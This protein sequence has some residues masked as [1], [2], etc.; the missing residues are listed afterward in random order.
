MTKAGIYLRF[1]GPSDWTEFREGSRIV[2]HGPNRE[3]LIVSG[4]LITGEGPGEELEHWKRVLFERTV[5]MVKRTAADPDLRIT[6]D[7]ASDPRVSEFECWTMR[8]ETAQ[9]ET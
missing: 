5:E 1:T 2:Y 7:L 8:T 6:R 3:E 9:G 4:S